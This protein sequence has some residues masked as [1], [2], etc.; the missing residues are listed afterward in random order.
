MELQ[1]K[2]LHRLLTVVVLM[3]VSDKSVDFVLLGQQRINELDQSLLALQGSYRMHG[4]GLKMQH[5]RA[6]L[7]GLVVLLF[8]TLLGSHLVGLDPRLHAGE[9]SSKAFS[10]VNFGFGL[11]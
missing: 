9:V 10:K 4:I 1:A 11:G 8:L 2:L 7:A 6:A 3:E 5:T